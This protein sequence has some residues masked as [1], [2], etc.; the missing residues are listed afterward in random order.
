MFILYASIIII[1]YLIMIENENIIPTLSENFYSKYIKRLLDIILSGIALILLSPVFLIVTLL[2]WHFHG[3][4]AIYK[5]KRPGKDNKIFHLYKFRSMTNDRDSDG[6]LLP[7]EKRLTPFGI[8]IRKFSIDELPQIYNIF[9]GDMSIIGPRPLLVEYVKLYSPRHAMRQSVRPGLVCLT[10]KTGKL[11]WRS[12][13]END[14][15]YV[16]NVSFLYDLKMLLKLIA[17]V[18]KHADYRALDTRV[19]FNGSNLDETRTKEEIGEV[20]HFNSLQ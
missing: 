10:D 20:S 14:V 16:E 4:P 1:Q 5:S 19:P 12:Q 18:F 7:E 9:V 13:F 15:K 2:E 8:F 3:R 17:E 6:Y 11:T